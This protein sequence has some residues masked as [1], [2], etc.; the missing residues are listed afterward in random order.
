MLLAS[1][2]GLALPA[3]QAGTYSANFNDGNTPP[4]MT[5]F[6]SAKTLATGGAVNGTFNMH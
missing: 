4:G 3:T 1:L 5:L 2:A 6:G